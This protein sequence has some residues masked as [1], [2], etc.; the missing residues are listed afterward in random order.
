MVL[1]CTGHRSAYLSIFCSSSYD[2]SPKTATMYVVQVNSLKCS[3]S[4][5]TEQVPSS[6]ADV[7]SDSPQFPVIARHW[8]LI[9]VY[10]TARRFSL[11]YNRLFKPISSNV[12]SF[13]INLNIYLQSVS[14]SKWSLS[15]IFS[16]Q[17]TK[18]ICLLNNACHTTRN[19]FHH[20][21]L[22]WRTTI[23]VSIQ[24]F[25]LRSEEKRAPRRPKLRWKDNIKMDHQEWNGEKWTRLIW[26]RMRTCNVVL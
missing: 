3:V 13:K 4:K 17:N 24:S 11:A 19:W 9:V 21:N 14:S 18:S 23:I 15:H 20:H 2:L 26:L 12:I 22:C 1:S 5:P 6:A 25:S 8:D 10:T 16:H 7:S